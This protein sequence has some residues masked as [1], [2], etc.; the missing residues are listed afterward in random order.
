M[1]EKTPLMQHPRPLYAWAILILSVIFNAYSFTLQSVPG[2]KVLVGDSPEKLIDYVYAMSG[3]FYAF[4]LF[5]IP[6][7][8]LIDRFGSRVLPTAGIFLCALG[9]ICFSQ[10]TTSW[11]MGLSRFIMGAGGAFS[12]LN[13][14]KLISNWFQPKR[15]AYLLGM[16]VALG[17]LLIVFLRLLFTKLS[18]VLDWRGALLSYGLGGLIFACIFFFVVQDIPGSRYTVHGLLE[19][20]KRFWDDIKGIFNNA[21]VWIIGIAVG[22][23]IGPL[24]SFEALWS[25]PFLE[26]VYKVP[27]SLAILFNFFF[28]IGYAIGAVFF[29]RVSTSLGRRKI[30]IPWGI[31]FSLLMIIIILYPPYMGVQVTAISF[32]TLGF[33]ASIVNLGFVS[34]HEQN[35]PHVTATAVGVVNTFYAFFAAISQSLIGVFLQLG[36]KIEHSQGFST[37]AY[38]ISLIRLP[39]YLLIA[40]IFSFFIK[41]TYCKQ[42]TKTNENL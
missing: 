24:F 25:V 31:G 27:Q 30:L 28:V 34:I 14:L 19:N 15:F 38:Q 21:Q 10:S 42:V 9:A 2:L 40:L 11:Q 4:A 37:H 39:V 33:A 20:K 32:F 13:A 7:G 18:L 8:L 23:I 36:Q 29:G 17:T 3:F 41:E 35:P 16:F 5:Q 22:L 1:S 26:T 12:F 6:I